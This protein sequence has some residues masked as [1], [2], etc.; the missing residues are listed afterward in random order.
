[1]SRWSK[2]EVVGGTAYEKKTHF[3]QLIPRELFQVAKKKRRGRE[4]KQ[5]RRGSGRVE[6]KRR[7]KRG[8]REK[9]RSSEEK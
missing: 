2:A 5:K 9:S 4:V 1:M 7:R 8:G 3:D 6:K